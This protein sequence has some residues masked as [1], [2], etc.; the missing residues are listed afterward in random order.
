MYI[1]TQEE[2]YGKK[3]IVTLILCL[4]APSGIYAGILSER[5]MMNPEQPWSGI[6]QLL[7]FFSIPLGML[8]KLINIPLFWWGMGIS[9]LIQFGLCWLLVKSPKITPKRATGISITL[10]MLNLF[11]LSCINS[12][13]G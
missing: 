8:F 10:G 12:M 5:L 9:S 3:N 2:R 11:I 1:P 6:V 4:M 13:K 7:F